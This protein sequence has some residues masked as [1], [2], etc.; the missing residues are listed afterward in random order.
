[1]SSVIRV[2]TD[3]AMEMSFRVAK[4]PSLTVDG[5]V[6]TKSKP[7]LVMG[8]ELHGGVE[9]RMVRTSTTT[10]MATKRRTLEHHKMDE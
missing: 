1:M 8:M 6:V 5:E 2:E 10:I 7:G 4:E 9:K 3:P